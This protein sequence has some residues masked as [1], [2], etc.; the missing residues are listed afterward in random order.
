M[1][2]VEIIG[3]KTIIELKV[4]PANLFFKTI[5]FIIA[6]IP[7]FIILAILFSE[8]K[9]E[10]PFGFFLGFIFLG[11]ISFF[12]FRLF[13]WNSYGKETYI[14]TNN[15]FTAVNDYKW[16]KDNKR[17]VSNYSKMELFYAYADNTSKLFELYETNHINK[18]EELV[19]IF[20]I[21]EVPYISVVKQNKKDIEYLFKTEIG[22][23][24]PIIITIPTEFN[25]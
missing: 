24:R 23:I 3:N 6:A 19:I 15:E 20:L 25:Y 8:G 14:I 1:I 13:L 17:A 7:L 12:L 5:L 22:K 16:F 2:N 9:I 11:G 10:S 4:R 21:D 18:E